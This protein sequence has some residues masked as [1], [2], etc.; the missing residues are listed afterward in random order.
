MHRILLRVVQFALR[1][2]LIESNR[3]EKDK[4][5]LLRKRKLI[6][7]S[8][9]HISPC[10]SNIALRV[11][12]I[13]MY[14]LT[15][16]PWIRRDTFFT[17]TGSGLQLV[18][19]SSGFE[20]SGS[21]AYRLFRTIHPFLDGSHS[22][23]E[24]REATGESWPMVERFLEPLA[25]HGFLRWIPSSDVSAM[26]VVDRASH[27]DQVAFLAQFTDTPH[28]RFRRFSTVKALVIGSSPLAESLVKNLKEN[29]ASDVSATHDWRAKEIATVPAEIEFNDYELIVVDH[30]S[31]DAL[32]LLDDHR[33]LAVTAHKNQLRALT[34]PWENPAAEQT[35]DTVSFTW[36]DA[37]SSLGM[38]AVDEQRQTT[39]RQLRESTTA[40]DARALAEPI[41]RMFGALLAYEIFKGVTG[42]ITPETSRKVLALNGL[43][44]E[45]TAHPVYAAPTWGEPRRVEV[46]GPTAAPLRVESSRADEYDTNWAHLAD[47]M[48]LPVQEI[49]DLDLEQVPVKIS[50]VISGE[51][52]DRAASLWTT[53]D[54]RIEALSRAYERHF[55]AFAPEDPRY[56]GS[57][58]VDI[59]P[60][61][62]V[63]R[64]LRAAACAAALSGDY[65]TGRTCDLEAQGQAP[66]F[67]RATAPEL[68]YADMGVFGDWHVG[69]AHESGRWA[70]AAAPEL[71]A[72]LV[73]AGVEVIG[74]R[75]A[76]VPLGE[77]EP[78]RLLGEAA[79]PEVTF[80]V[81]EL[82][83]AFAADLGLHVY[84]TTSEVRR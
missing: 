38:R 61:Q 48:T 73:S 49:S 60:R 28:E 74:A 36:L 81:Y 83:N 27:A 32:Q 51:E 37:L 78:Q 71:P 57:L 25:E 64:S 46:P 42:A 62:A 34:R 69:L 39:V 17:D 21:S 55:A 50:A 63:L 8:E 66:D 76:N 72:A 7:S 29:G 77:G 3:W 11:A 20:I 67:V 23:Q 30:E 45:T 52:T 44:G 56:R 84:S 2:D 47:P 58:G 31:L 5:Q 59:D 82:P 80:T 79:P 22:V 41:Q 10:Y 16:H 6:N 19:A 14:S 12:S 15:D 53:A 35:N 43:T 13:N 26:S 18:N 65:R 70:V 68:S 1:F 9:R 33:V 40:A 54:A 4:V 24:I 75:Q